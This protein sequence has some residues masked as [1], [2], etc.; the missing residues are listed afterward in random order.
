MSAIEQSDTGT[1]PNALTL[2]G[3]S[4]QPEPEHGTDVGDQAS[5]IVATTNTS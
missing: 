3:S 2:D 1:Q 4:S 5:G